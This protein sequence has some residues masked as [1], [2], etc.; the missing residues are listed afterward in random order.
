MRVHSDYVTDSSAYTNVYLQEPHTDYF[1]VF[2]SQRV[3][4]AFF[5]WFD[6]LTFTT[7]CYH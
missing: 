5:Q 2:V 4:I 6:L 1:P 3:G 7:T